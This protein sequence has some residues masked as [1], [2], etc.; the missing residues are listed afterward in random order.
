MRIFSCLVM[1][2]LTLFRGQQVT[3]AAR[4]AVRVWANQVL[5]S[6][7]PYMVMSNVIIER[8][9]CSGKPSIFYLLPVLGMLT[10]S[11]NGALV[12][13]AGLNGHRI[14]KRTLFAL[15]ALTGTLSPV[16]I[17]YTVTR[18]LGYTNGYALLFLHISAAIASA[19][20]ILTVFP[21][22]DDATVSTLQQPDKAQS[23]IGKSVNAILN[24]GGCLVFFS[25]VA[26]C[27]DVL[28]PFLPLAA[29]LF[30][31]GIL[32]I[33]G[34]LERLAQSSIAPL[35]KMLMGMWLSS[36][37]GISILSQNHA[38]LCTCGIRMRHLVWIGMLR[39]CVCML[40]TVLALS[41]SVM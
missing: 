41:V 37:G 38:F 6:L 8:L 1:M 24:V 29:R 17:C 5:P 31:H 36:F 21:D 18:W 20:L 19:M 39:A 27:V 7:F 4:E 16:F 11:P 34:G 26:S 40:L 2:A 10:G 32:E 23:G 9:T 35:P 3:A 12:L 33:S 13:A 30:L 22:S 28:F 25:A 15:C 14:A